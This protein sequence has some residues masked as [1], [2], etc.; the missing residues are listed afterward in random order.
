[1][2]FR[3]LMQVSLLIFPSLKSTHL[4]GQIETHFEQFMHNDLSIDILHSEILLISPNI[5]PIGQILMQKNLALYKVNIIT[6]IEAI[7]P[8]LFNV[9]NEPK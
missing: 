8:T 1:M 7:I 4:E 9:I 2:H 6:K 5:A 3:H